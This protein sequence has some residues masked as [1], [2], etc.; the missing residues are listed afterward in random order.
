M[1][2]L[3][4]PTVC[5]ITAI[6]FYCW[7]LFNSV[8]RDDQDKPGDFL[9]EPPATVGMWLGLIFAVA[10]K[11]TKYASFDPAK[12]MAYLSLSSDEKYKSK[13]AVDIV[14]ARM[15]KGGA[16][17]FNIL[18]LNWIMN[19]KTTVEKST[20]IVSFVAVAVMMVIWIGSTWFLAGAIKRKSDEKL[21]NEQKENTVEIEVENLKKTLTENEGEIETNI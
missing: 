15:G 8:Y 18:A 12:E 19:K 5:T 17:L 10:T 21:L 13:A 16:A 2:A 3:S 7:V 9:P 1:T 11:A 4:A 6:T 20:Q 14:G